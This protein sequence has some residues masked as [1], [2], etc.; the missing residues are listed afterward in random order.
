[1]SPVSLLFHGH[2]WHSSQLGCIFFCAASTS[3]TSSSPSPS[4][5][6]GNRK[7]PAFS[8]CTA[9]LHPFVLQNE[10]QDVSSPP[11]FLSVRDAIQHQAGHDRARERRFMPPASSS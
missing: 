11:D 7:L 4:A 8:L 1:M 3:S 10:W 6:A 5:A 2:K 9:L